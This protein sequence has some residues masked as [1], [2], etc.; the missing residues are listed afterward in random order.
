[1]VRLDPWLRLEIEVPG[2]SDAA[3]GR[4]ARVEVRN[5]GGAFS[6]ETSPTDLPR[7]PRSS[8]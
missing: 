6:L 4:R 2:G 5:A 8:T 7:L 3:V 1:M